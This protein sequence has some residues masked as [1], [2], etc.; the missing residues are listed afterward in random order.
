MLW[1]RRRSRPLEQASERATARLYEREA[2]RGRKADAGH[3]P[4]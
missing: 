3:V 2:E 1:Q 4:M